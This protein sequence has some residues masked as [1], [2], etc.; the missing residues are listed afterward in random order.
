MEEELY[1]GKI[2]IKLKDIM[3]QKQISIYKL[4]KMTH[5][6]YEIIKKYYTNEISRYDDNTLIKLCYFLN[7]NISDLIVYKK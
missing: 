1:Y 5:L 4:S 7:C 3:E 6:K 2:A